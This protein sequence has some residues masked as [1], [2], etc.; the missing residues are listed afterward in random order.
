MKGTCV[1]WLMR[2]WPQAVRKHLGWSLVGSTFHSSFLLMC[3]VK[4]AGDRSNTW[5]PV[6]YMR[7]RLNSWLLAP[8]FGLVAQSPSLLAFGEKTNQMLYLSKNAAFFLVGGRSECNNILVWASTCNASIP[9]GYQF[10]SWQLHIQRSSLP[11]TEGRG[12]CLKSLDPELTW[13]TRK[14]LLVSDWVSSESWVEVEQCGREG[15]HRLGKVTVVSALRHSSD[16]P[17]V[18]LRATAQV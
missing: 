5:V 10:L 17:N 8:G 1:D 6:S 16:R 2:M 14:R 18:W 15:N 12:W 11:M 9:Y 7:S 13:E 3:T 4:E